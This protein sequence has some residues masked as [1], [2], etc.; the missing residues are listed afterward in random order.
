MTSRPSLA[1]AVVVAVVVCA[2]GAVLGY[3]RL[4]EDGYAI[5]PT[6]T[7][8]AHETDESQTPQELFQHSY[9]VV[10][11][12]VLGWEPSRTAG[13]RREE[14][15][16]DRVIRV[17]VDGALGQDAGIARVEPGQVIR[18][19][20]GSWNGDRKGLV[21]NNVTWS[22]A[23]ERGIWFLSRSR[24]DG[25]PTWPRCTETTYRLTSSYGRL[26]Y[27]A[28]FSPLAAGGP[29]GI[30]PYESLWRSAR[31]S[32]G[33]LDAAAGFVASLGY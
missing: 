18:I 12:E 5:R 7:A 9:V 19:I 16:T 14:Q 15:E 13:Q 23:G 3:H 30:D 17:R 8:I 31:G 28:L 20:E 33:D 4:D 32:L 26:R 24:S 25:C 10:R 6:R 29:S 27:P 21:I 22:E 11:G 2:I 1:L